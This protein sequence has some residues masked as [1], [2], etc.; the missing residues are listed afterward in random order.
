MKRTLQSLP[1]PEPPCT[2][3]A[4]RTASGQPR[5]AASALPTCTGLRPPRQLEGPGWGERGKGEATHLHHPHQGFRV[6]L[7]DALKG[8]RW[9][10]EDGG[11]DGGT[12]RHGSVRRGVALWGTAGGQAAPPRWGRS[13]L[14]TCLVRGTPGL[15]RSR[16]RGCGRQGARGPGSMV[17]RQ[18]H[19]RPARPRAQLHPANASPPPLCPGTACPFLSQRFCLC[20]NTPYTHARRAWPRPL[21][22]APGAPGPATACA[23]PTGRGRTRGCPR[24]VAITEGRAVPPACE[25][26]SP[27][28]CPRSR[29][30]VR[31]SG[32]ARRHVPTLSPLAVAVPRVTAPGAAGRGL[33]ASGG[34]CHASDPCISVLQ[35]QTVVDSTLPRSLDPTAV[36]RLRRPRPRPT[37]RGTGAR[38]S[39]LA[40]RLATLH[41]CFAVR[42]LFP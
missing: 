11:R 9:E 1:T 37:S 7:E 19:A 29:A 39:L 21:Q 22:G 35:G 18:P 40:G 13:W 3:P 30:A 12:G 24:A 41:V 6:S 23:P 31:L 32:D 36:M 10:P 14:C 8:R 5:H 15:A 38:W 17:E 25:Q 28:R 34:S 20:L 42:G 27:S 4:A 26:C 2:H 16:R 33:A